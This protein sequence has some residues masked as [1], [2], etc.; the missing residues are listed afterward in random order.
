M[1]VLELESTPEIQDLRK[2]VG[3]FLTEFIYPNEKTLDAG[4]DEAR[5]TLKSIQAEAKKRY[6]WALGLPKEIRGGGLPFMHYVLVNEIVGRSEYAI[7]GLGTHSAQD[8][9]MLHFYGNNE[10]KKRWLAPL[11]NG[12]IYPCFSMT[13]P[14]VSG[15]DPTGL[16]TRAV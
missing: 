8:A 16:Q 13:E 1:N 15:A 4:G 10:Q 12:E 11:V 3:G 2:K 9:T 6:L 5:K 7:A 14:E